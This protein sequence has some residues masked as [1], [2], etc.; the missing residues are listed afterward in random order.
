[1]AAETAKLALVCA[2]GTGGHLFPAQALAEEL[3]GRGWSVHLATD[4]RVEAYGQD[5]PAAETH[6]LP[7][8]TPSG[9]GLISKAMAGLTLARGVLAARGLI[10]RLKPNTVIGFGGY[11]TVP[12]LFAASALRVPSVIHEANAVLGRAN[13]FLA[14]RVL[15]IA[16]STPSLKLD[17]TLSDKVVETGNPVRPAVITASE[18]PYPERGA[19][20]PFRLL[21]FGGSQGARVFSDLLPEAL[22]AMPASARGLIHLTQQCR[23]EDLDRS[24]AAFEPLGLAALELAPFFRDLPSRIANNH[25]TVCRSGASTVSELGVIGRPGLLVPLPGAI[26]QDQRANAVAL[27]AAGGAWM[28]DQTELTP[29]RLAAEL[30]ALMEIPARLSTAAEKAKAYGRPDAAARLADLVE[31]VAARGR[32]D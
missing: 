8:A 6:I 28:I 32:K 27:E 23:P 26:D 11:P 30:A 19:G 29:T 7:S 17:G 25:L 14:P 15:S 3:A 21:V 31:S 20:D 13:K 2:G 1:M 9:G 24:Q 16:T 5:F 4:H 22:E 18:I 12:P 10:R